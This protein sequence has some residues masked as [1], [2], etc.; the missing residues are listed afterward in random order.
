M[1][2]FEEADGDLAIEFVVFD[3]QYAR[4]TDGRE[5]DF[6]RGG[7]DLADR[8]ATGA[9]NLNNGI[10]ENGGGHGLDQDTF[11]GCLLGLT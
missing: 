1:S 4:T 5:S 9:D 3:E 2:I 11:E 6:R 7:L 8:V 10:E